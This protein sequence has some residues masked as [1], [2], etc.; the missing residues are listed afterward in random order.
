M[1]ESESDVNQRDD[2]KSYRQNMYLLCC[3]RYIR[4][5]SAFQINSGKSFWVRLKKRN[6]ANVCRGLRVVYAA[7][8]FPDVLILPKVTF[9]Q[10]FAVESVFQLLPSRLV[11]VCC[12]TQAKCNKTEREMSKAVELENMSS[13]YFIFYFSSCYLTLDNKLHMRERR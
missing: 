2:V 12:T 13:V 10:L 11:I 7:F 9:D 4:V 1:G 3:L 5:S 8:S 6:R